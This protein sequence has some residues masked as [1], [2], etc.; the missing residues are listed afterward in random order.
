MQ[1]KKTLATS[2][3]LRKNHKANTALFA[4]GEKT[5]S[6]ENMPVSIVAISEME[7]KIMVLRFSRGVKKNLFPQKKESQKKKKI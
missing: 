6:Q 2:T 7:K 4:V 5:E 1:D 3:V